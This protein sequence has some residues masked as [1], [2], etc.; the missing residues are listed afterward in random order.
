MR[1]ILE[2]AGYVHSFRA[3][4]NRSR[5]PG[6]GQVQRPLPVHAPGLKGLRSGRPVAEDGLMLDAFIRSLPKPETH[7]HL[8]GAVPFELLQRLDPVRHAKPP[9]SWA[10]D[11][12]YPSFADFDRHLLGMACPWYTS[13]ERYHEAAAII[14]RRLVEEQNVRY[15]EASFASGVLEFTGMDGAAVAEA[16]QSAAPVGLHVRVFMGIHHNGCNERTEAFLDDCVNWAHLDGID[17]H[18]EE[19]VPVEPWTPRLWQRFREAGKMTKAHAG[20][21]LGPDFVRKVINELGVTRIEHG[22]RAALDPSLLDELRE[23]D[24]T[25]DLCPISNLKL[26][27]V[28]SIADHSIRRIFDAGV[29]C[30]VS[31]DDPMCFGN[32]LF[33]DYKELATDCNFTPAELAKLARNGFEI[34]LL[35]ADTKAALL[36]E[37]DAV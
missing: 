23:R 26:G 13:P 1:A 31:T 33:D 22:E 28:T 34:A 8:E 21:F 30:T 19:T 37:V 16:I 24:I 9:M 32:T 10:R 7:L 3:R 14:F 6:Q 2:L 15:V 20:E 11:Y 27:I 5:A 25:L 12:R 4:K 17:L 35:D 36:R 29:R 18:G